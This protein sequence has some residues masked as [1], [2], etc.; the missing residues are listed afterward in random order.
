[1]QPPRGPP[2]PD[3]G[4]QYRLLLPCNLIVRKD[5]EGVLVG[6]ISPHE[7]TGLTKRDGLE[8]F[9]DHVASIL[10]RVLEASRWP[11]PPT[12]LAGC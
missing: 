6:A 1:M 3:R 5:G 2:G 11:G 8:P 4:A 7:L 10:E 9:A 12:L